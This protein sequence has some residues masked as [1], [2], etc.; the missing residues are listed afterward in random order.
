M[1][2][3]KAF[4]AT[5]EVYRWTHSVNIVVQVIALRDKE[6]GT[7]SYVSKSQTSGTSIRQKSLVKLMK[8][9][10]KSFENPASCSSHYLCLDGTYPQTALLQSISRGLLDCENFHCLAR[11]LYPGAVTFSVF[12]YKRWGDLMSLSCA[13]CCFLPLTFMAGQSERK[14]LD[15]WS[16]NQLNVQDSQLWGNGRSQHRAQRIDDVFIHSLLIVAVC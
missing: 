3:K 8:M 7:W 1:L 11:S 9:R 4:R 5:F 14:E 2:R 10:G 13:H 6:D 12:T 15:Y 16:R